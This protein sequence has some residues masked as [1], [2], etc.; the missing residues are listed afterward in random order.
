MPKIKIN[1]FGEGIEIRQLQLE[2]ETYH[3]WDTIATRKKLLLPDLLLNPF[4]YYDLKDKRYKELPDINAKLISGM[5]DTPKSLIEIWFNRKKILKIP[6][7]EL[8]NEML[9]FPLFK[10]DKNQDFLTHKLEN[11]I[12][13]V[14]KTIGLLSSKQLEITSK[15]LNIYDFNFSITT[16]GDN[17]FLSNIKYQNQ[18]FKF[19][20][21]DAIITYQNAF[22]IK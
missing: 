10:V 18:N 6:S 2:S 16:F 5:V 12:Y 13:V 14:Q 15:R 19:L 17:Q 22:E 8:F 21:S 11:G 7:Q 3:H 4:F 1:T 20:K 9:L